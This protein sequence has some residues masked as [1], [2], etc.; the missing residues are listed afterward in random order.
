[1]GYGGGGTNITINQYMDNRGA[2]QELIQQL[3]AY[4]KANNEALKADILDTI[5]R[6]RRRG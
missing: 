2:T 1:M 6:Q 4:T 5:A 3:P